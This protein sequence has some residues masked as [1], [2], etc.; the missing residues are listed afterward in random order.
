MIPVQRSEEKMLVI[1]TPVN[2][3]SHEELNILVRNSHF[4]FSYDRL[5][6]EEGNYVWDN[7]DFGR[8]TYAGITRRY[9]PEWVGWHHIDEAKIRGDGK[10]LYKLPWNSKIESAEP[11]VKD[12]YH[13]WWQ[14]W[15]MDIIQ[16][17][18]VAAYTF[19]F[20]I[21]GSPSIKV[22]QTTLNHLGKD[23]KVTGRMS[24]REAELI[25]QLD[26][27]IYLESLR[28]ARRQFYYR[29]SLKPHRVKGPS[30]KYLR[31]TTGYKNYLKPFRPITIQ[32]GYV[33][34]CTQKKFL[35]GWLIRADRISPAIRKRINKPNTPT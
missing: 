14:S 10:R 5:R 6:R 1:S 32:D 19:D 31:D 30:G 18:L 29:I 2:M 21:C 13:E 33:Y 4:D 17:S 34:G 9:N 22:I 16:D 11:Y 20:A 23:I 26:P 28:I 3:E 25:N 7:H 24:A 12:Y 35:P 8:E 15:N 27:L